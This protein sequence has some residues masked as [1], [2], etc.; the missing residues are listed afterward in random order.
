MWEQVALSA[1][2]SYVNIQILCSDT[3]EH[4]LRVETR[5]P[6]V[7]GL[8]L[9]TW[10]EVENREYHDWTVERIVID[11]AGRTELECIEELISKLPP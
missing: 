11:T 2:A 9:P 8:K 5:A 7:P 3:R 1:K 6:T 4:R 10:I